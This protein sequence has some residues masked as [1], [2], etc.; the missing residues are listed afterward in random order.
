[1]GVI[2]LEQMNFVGKWWFQF[3]DD[4]YHRETYHKGQVQE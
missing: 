3:R 2:N 1:M 4:S